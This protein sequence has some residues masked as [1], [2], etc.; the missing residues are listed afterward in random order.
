MSSG[1]GR[2]AGYLSSL[3]GLRVR[4][5]RVPE[6]GREAEITPAPGKCGADVI[7]H[8]ANRV[9]TVGFGYVE[10]RHAGRWVGGPFLSIGELLTSLALTYGSLGHVCYA[11]VAD[12]VPAMAE[13][14]DSG[15][16]CAAIR[17]DQISDGRCPCCRGAFCKECL[18]PA[19]RERG[20]IML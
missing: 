15:A 1:S 10:E 6:P 8:Y 7:G 4:A 18:E 12:A 16:I 5:A 2:G 19:G 9:R 14:I 17:C 13:Q 11:C 20:F 3:G